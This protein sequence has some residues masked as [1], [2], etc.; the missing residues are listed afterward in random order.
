MHGSFEEGLR[1]EQFGT[2]GKKASDSLM[3]EMVFN[4][5]EADEKNYSRH[6]RR[7]QSWSAQPAQM[8]TVSPWCT[9]R[10]AQSVGGLAHGDS[11]GTVGA[12]SK[13]HQKCV[14]RGE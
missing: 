14:W 8:Q 13:L 9:G 1:K 10:G 6:A 5:D 4:E 7:R 11:W 12:A 2:G 3:E